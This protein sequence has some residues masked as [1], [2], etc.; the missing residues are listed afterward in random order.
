MYRI[1]A[2]ACA[3]LQGKHQVTDCDGQTHYI[4]LDNVAWID[5]KQQPEHDR[6]ICQLVGHKIKVWWP[7][8]KRFYKSTVV[9]YNAA[10]VG[11]SLSALPPVVVCARRVGLVVDCVGTVLPHALILLAAVLFDHM[12]NQ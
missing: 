9:R 10:E 11:L 8:D 1:N 12:A 5:R 3:L 4:D 6:L 7:D 2:E